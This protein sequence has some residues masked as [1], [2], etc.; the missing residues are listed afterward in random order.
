MNPKI[1]DQVLVI[2]TKSGKT[3]SDHFNKVKRENMGKKEPAA[4]PVNVR[5]KVV[6]DSKQRPPKTSK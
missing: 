3:L 5:T 4:K 1:K 6:V 2:V